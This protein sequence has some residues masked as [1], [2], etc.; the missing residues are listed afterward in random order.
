MSEVAKSLAAALAPDPF[1][2][3]VSV[4]A[5][6]ENHRLDILQTYFELAIAEALAIGEVQFSAPDGA[7]LWITNE[8]TPQAVEEH[9]GQR[10]QALQSLLGT[11]GF[12]HFVDISNAMESQLPPG[13]SNAWYLSILGVHPAARGKGLARQLLEKTLARADAGAFDCYLE[14]FNP[15]SLPFYE[16][17]GFTEKLACHEPV[18]G[19]EYW[20]M[21]RRA[22]A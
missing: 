20:V 8:A 14:T 10:K 2:R 22:S 4:A 13:L 18:T 6:D 9:S 1:Y 19:R 15:L 5:T 21:I 17:L 12:S 3:A 16:R 7:A 11:V